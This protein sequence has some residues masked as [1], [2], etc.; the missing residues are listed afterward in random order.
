MSGPRLRTSSSTSSVIPKESKLR[1][2]STEKFVSAVKEEGRRDGEKAFLSVPKNA[3]ED[4][5]NYT[6]F[7]RHLYDLSMELLPEYLGQRRAK[8]TQ[9]E[10]LAYFEGFSE[11]VTSSIK[12]LESEFIH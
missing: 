6:S 10:H 8:L 4:A 1:S 2:L 5:T 9:E 7:F 12:K 11:S 3:D